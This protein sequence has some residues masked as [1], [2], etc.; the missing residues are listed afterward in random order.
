MRLID[1]SDLEEHADESGDRLYCLPS[2][3]RVDVLKRS[4]IYAATAG[5][6]IITD[7]DG[8]TTIDPNSMNIGSLDLVKLNEH[9][10]TSVVIKAQVG[11]D[12]I[13]GKNKL[14]DFY[15]TLDEKSGE[16]VDEVVEE[17]WNRTEADEEKKASLI[18]L[19]ISPLPEN[20]SEE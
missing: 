7:E 2:P 16:W 12:V 14:L 20:P 1:E 3:R 19:P 15:R 17:V 6:S 18:S 4:G 11:S 9:K 5:R 8:N 10:F 13:V